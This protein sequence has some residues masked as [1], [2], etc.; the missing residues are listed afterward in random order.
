MR[1]PPGPARLPLLAILLLPLVVLSAHSDPPAAGPGKRIDDFT[2]KDGGAKSWS[3]ADVKGRQAVVVVFLGTECP[4]SNAYLPRLADLARRYETQGVAFV[5]VNANRQDSPE[6]VAAHARKNALPFPVLKDGGNVVADRFEAERTPEAFVLDAGR[7]VRYRGRVDDQVGVGYRRPKPTRDDLVEALDEVLAGKP[8]SRPRTEVAGCHIARVAR[9]K[10]E[11]TVTYARDVA[12]ILQKH[13]QECHRPGQI[14]PMALLT[15]EDAAA[16]AETIGDVVRERR[17]PPW[18]ADPD[19]GHFAN[20][21]SLAAADRDKVLTWVKQG[22]P[23]GDRKDLPPARAFASDWAIGKPDVVFTM[24]RSFTVPAQAPRGVRYQYIVVETNFKEDVWVQAAEA[25]PGNRAVVHH[26]IVYVR[27]PGQR[28]QR[29]ADGIG[30]GMLV[31]YA[32]GDMPVQLEPGRAKK[33]PRGSVLAFQMHYTPNGTEQTD[34]SSVGLVFAKGPPQYE[35][36]TRAIAQQLFAIPAGAKN[37]EVRSASVFPEDVLLVGLF[38]HM[39]LRGKSFA[40]R[41]VYPDGKAE[42][43]LSVPRYDFGWQ[44]TYRLAEPLRLPAGT[45]VECT[46]HFDN[47]AD[48]PNNPDPNKAVTWGDQTWEEMMIGF[49]DYTVVRGA[50]GKGGE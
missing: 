50:G 16:W 25:R 2:L 33:I 36:R 35:V 18:F 30:D 29:N 8:V 19:H 6:A 12:P 47:S 22:C 41:V 28:R 42:V 5:A 40:Y 27:Q 15:Y 39:H 34:C 23:E 11:A 46:A 7:V 48:N 1:M 26:I 37:H 3:L 20:D 32:P 14:G 13:C 43:L 38:P 9:P 21:R 10:G 31:A 17:M 44:T 49:V 24:P 45:R 4:I